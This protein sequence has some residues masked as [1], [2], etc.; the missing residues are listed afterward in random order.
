[1]HNQLTSFEDPTLC[2]RRSDIVVSYLGLR[3]SQCLPHRRRC[4]HDVVR[5]RRLAIMIGVASADGV[6]L[7][8]DFGQHGISVSVD[9]DVLQA[10]A[11]T[12][13]PFSRHGDNHLAITVVVVVALRRA[14]VVSAL[15]EAIDGHVRTRVSSHGMR[16]MVLGVHVAGLAVVGVILSVAVARLAKQVAARAACP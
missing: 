10:S 9:L 2:I 8:H 11:S 12:T 6:T 14:S 16:A 13:V 3:N 1:M 4:I 5:T 15:G 7:I